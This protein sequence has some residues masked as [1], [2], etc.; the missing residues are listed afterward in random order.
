VVVA[1]GKPVKQIQFNEEQHRELALKLPAEKVLA[2]PGQPWVQ[3]IVYDTAGKLA[4]TN[5]VWIDTT[6][7]SLAMPKTVETTIVTVTITLVKTDTVTHTVTV[8]QPVTK[9]A[10]TTL[11]ATETLTIT[12]EEIIEKMVTVG[13]RARQQRQPSYSAW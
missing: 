13:G 9:T 10:T 7:K 12:S 8:T 3:V 5:P 11:T 2:T 6:V 1:N 4:M